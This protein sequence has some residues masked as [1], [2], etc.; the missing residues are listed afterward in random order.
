MQNT[1]LKAGLASFSR[2]CF[3]ASQVMNLQHFVPLGCEI[4]DI[5]QSRAGIPGKLFQHS[6]A[7][8]HFGTEPLQR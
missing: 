2:P 6:V 5:F 7:F 4:V 8:K 1:I 3:G